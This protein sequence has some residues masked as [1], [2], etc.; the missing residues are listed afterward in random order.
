MAAKRKEYVPSTRDSRVEE[1][2]ELQQQMWNV[3]GNFNTMWQA[4]S[5][6]VLPNYSDFIMQWA[7]GQRR[8]NKVFDS[9]APLALEHF[10]AA[11]ESM[12]C[13]AS[14]RW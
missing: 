12:L 9:T 1:I 10:C 8:T 4:V 5:E 13:P 14:T 11:M 6:R 7:E 2:I 3:R